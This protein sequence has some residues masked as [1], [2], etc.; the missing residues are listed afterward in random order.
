MSKRRSVSAEL[1]HKRHRVRRE[2]GRTV[3]ACFTIS[4]PRIRL[5]TRGVFAPT[6][7]HGLG[8]V[9]QN[10]RRGFGH[11][12]PACCLTLL[13]AVRAGLPHRSVRLGVC[14]SQPPSAPNRRSHRFPSRLIQSTMVNGLVVS[15]L[16]LVGM[17]AGEPAGSAIT[18]SVDLAQHVEQWGYRRYWLAE[19]HSISGLACSAT[20]VLFGHVARRDRYL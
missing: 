16:D 9:S 20:P 1:L 18:R 4:I 11:S 6:I 14:S 7:A 2:T 3:G 13:A 12:G 10:P 5:F 15:V 19:H 17:R 8:E